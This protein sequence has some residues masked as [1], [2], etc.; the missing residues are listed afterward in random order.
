MHSSDFHVIHQLSYLPSAK[1][2]ECFQFD[3]DLVESDE[4]SYIF[5]VQNFALVANHQ[6][7]LWLEWYAPAPKLDLESLLVYGLK[8]AATE[9][10]IHLHCSSDNLINLI[11]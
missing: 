7:L 10:V 11:S 3:D 8:K 4:V 1:A 5:L 6:F 2:I 9:L